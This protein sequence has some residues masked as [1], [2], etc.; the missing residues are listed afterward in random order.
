MRIEDI[1]NTKLNLDNKINKL[2]EQK[3]KDDK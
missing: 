2:E 3:L 1:Q